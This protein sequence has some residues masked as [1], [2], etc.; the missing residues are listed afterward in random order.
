MFNYILK[1]Y[2]FCTYGYLVKIWVMG[3]EDHKQ[4]HS[5]FYFKFL[6]KN[7]QANYGYV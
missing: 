5:S 3:G 7:Y 4:N 1:R 2:H 6:F